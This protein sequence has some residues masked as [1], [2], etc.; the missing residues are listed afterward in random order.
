MKTIVEE[1]RWI[2]GFTPRLSSSNSVDACNDSH[3]S[4]LRCSSKHGDG[5][6]SK[7]GKKRS[8]VLHAR[9]VCMKDRRKEILGSKKGIDCS[10][11]TRSIIA[12][13]KR[14]L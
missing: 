14:F 10:A 9:I 4:L 7:A 11:D 8:R 2:D 13:S 5:P 3:S 6:L 12:L 1:Q